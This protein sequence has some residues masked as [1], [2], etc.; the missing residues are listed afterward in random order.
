M[1]GALSTLTATATKAT[2]LMHLSLDEVL[3]MMRRPKSLAID[4]VWSGKHLGWIQARMPLQFDDESAI[5]EQSYVY[6][7]WRPK[8]SEKSESWGFNLIYRGGRAYAIHIQ[9][10]SLHENKAGKGRPLFG[11]VISGI[12]EHTW[13]SDGDGYAEPIAVPLDKPEVVWKMFLRRAC[14]NHGDFFHPD[15][16]QPSL[17]L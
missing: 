4:M 8:V 9:P 1:M 17:D 16:N 15:D 5:Q 11:Q 12:H 14:I 2:D 3:D 6:C 7:Q 13:S 10:D